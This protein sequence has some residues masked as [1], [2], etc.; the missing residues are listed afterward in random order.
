M[1]DVDRLRAQRV[2]TRVRT[3]ASELSG[4]DPAELDDG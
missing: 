3:V 4:C 1:G 2:L